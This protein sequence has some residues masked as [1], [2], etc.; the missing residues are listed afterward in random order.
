MLK[1]SFQIS[2]VVATI[3][4]PAFAAFEVGTPEDF[5]KLARPGLP[6]TVIYWPM[7]YDKDD[8]SSFCGGALNPEEID[9]PVMDF[10]AKTVFKDIGTCPGGLDAWWN[11]RWDSFDLQ[12]SAITAY[13]HQDGV[14]PAPNI[15]AALF[16]EMS[17]QPAPDTLL[18][19]VMNNLLVNTLTVGPNQ[20]ETRLGYH[21]NP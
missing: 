14:N 16:S 19:D 1:K 6:L 9:K 15:P 10:D 18:K 3:L 12:K 8:L 21:G 5:L 4:T 20:Y 13:Y 7:I 2:A 17:P 11:R